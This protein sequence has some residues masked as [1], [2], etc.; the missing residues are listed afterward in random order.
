MLFDDKEL[1]PKP[2]Y[3]AGPMNYTWHNG[4]GPYPTAAAY[5]FT[6]KESMAEQINKDYPDGVTFNL[7]RQP[8]HRGL[9]TVIGGIGFGWYGTPPKRFPHIGGVIIG[10]HVEV[11]SNV[12]I[13]RGAMGDTVI[14]DHV[15]IDNHVHVGHNCVIGEGAILTSH[16]VFGGSAVIGEGAFIGLGATIKNQVRVGARAVVGM[17]AVVVKDVEPD[18][19]VI[20]N[21][22]RPM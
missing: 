21:P 9:G 16:S 12:S 6:D 10:K 7:K 5:V 2:K 19:T 8:E 4:N 14:K 11:G 22:A 13:D 1:T 15:K 3:E 20:G 18:T 17:G